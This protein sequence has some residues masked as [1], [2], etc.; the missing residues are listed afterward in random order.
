MASN[1]SEPLIKKAIA[2]GRNWTGI[3]VTEVRDIHGREYP[4]AIEVFS[5]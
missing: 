3:P 4:L 5:A 2:N 1:S